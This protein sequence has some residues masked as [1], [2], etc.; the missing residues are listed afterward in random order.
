MAKHL[1]IAN[2]CRIRLLRRLWGMHWRVATASLNSVSRTLA[3]LSVGLISTLA[4]G[5]IARA[6]V[7][8]ARVIT[9]VSPSGPGSTPDVLSRILARQLSEQ[10]GNQVVVLNRVGAGTDIGTA[11]VAHAAPDGYTLLLG[12]IANTL[13]PHIKTS[14]GYK[15]EDLAPVSSVAAAADI[16]VVHPS[17]NISTVQELI[18]FLKS[19]PGTPAGH[20]GIGT[21]PHLSLELFRQ[22][23]GAEFTMIPFKGS[24]QAQQGMLAGE[25]PFMFNTSIGVLPLVRSGQVRAIAVSSAKRIA[26]LPDVPTVAE[27]GLPGFEVVAWFGLFAPAGTPK[28]IIDRLSA[29]T[30]RALATPQMRKL[31]DDLGAS[32]LGSE[33][34]AFS[35]Y[36]K[37]E[38]DRWGKLAKDLAMPVQ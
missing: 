29:E 4:L 13:N 27:S 2:E 35:A 10:L 14:V 6:E 30:R 18:A 34:D 26:A 5:G 38:Y 36:V 20:G 17:T 3:V 15:L 37:R 12:S 22:R 8:P 33:P 11:S 25:I 32:P 1:M 28:P 19:K 24:G 9:L 21:T 23:A 7:Y 31:L 16:L